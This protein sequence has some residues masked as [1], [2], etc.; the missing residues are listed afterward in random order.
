MNLTISMDGIADK[1]QALNDAV[2][3]GHMQLTSTVGLRFAGDVLPTLRR[4]VDYVDLTWAD[5]VEID[6]PGPVDPDVAYVR[7]WK[8]K[9]EVRLKVGGKVTVTG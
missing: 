1:L 8:D 9:A 4:G 6:L 7:I 3:Q 2:H 5:K